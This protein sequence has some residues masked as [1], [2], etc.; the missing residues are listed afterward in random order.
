MFN[1]FILDTWFILIIFII[2]IKIVIRCYSYIRYSY[3]FSVAVE[4]FININGVTIITYFNFKSLFVSTFVKWCGRK[5]Y[6]QIIKTVLYVIY[7]DST[8]IGNYTNKSLCLAVFEVNPVNSL[9]VALADP[10]I[11]N[12]N[13]QI[14]TN[15]LFNRIKWN[16]RASN[17]NRNITVIIRTI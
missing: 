4:R 13:D 16:D 5:S 3:L 10:V 1:N 9:Y 2:F 14:S 12:Y 11:F 8:F 17:N 7:N 15:E 6:I